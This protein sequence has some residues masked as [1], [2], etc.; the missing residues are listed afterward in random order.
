MF[1][2]ATFDLKDSNIFLKLTQLE[3]F[4]KLN[5]NFEHQVFYMKFCIHIVS[6]VN[7]HT[8]SFTTIQIYKYQQN[9]LKSLLFSL[10]FT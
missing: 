7:Q 8:E 2:I 3:K 6:Q 10:G 4:I 1:L 9:T 5:T